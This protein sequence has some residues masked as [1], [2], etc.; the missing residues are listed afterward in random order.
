VRGD[1]RA[2]A[3][4]RAWIV[5]GGD[6]G[7]MI[8]GELFATA[9]REGSPR[10]L[11]AVGAPVIPPARAALRHA[12][13]DM[14]LVAIETL[15][16]LRVNA[17]AADIRPLLDD[18]DER[19]RYAACAALGELYDRPSAPAIA[20]LAEKDPFP[21]A[22]V[23]TLGL[24][25]VPGTEVA[26]VRLSRHDDFQIRAAV[27][28]AL[29]AFHDVDFTPAFA[30]LARDPVPYVRM[31]A[32]EAMALQKRSDTAPILEGQLSDPDWRVRAAAATAI[33]AIGSVTSGNGLIPLLHD[34][35]SEVRGE[36]AMSLAVLKRRDALPALLALRD[37]PTEWGLR[38]IVTAIGLFGGAETIPILREF[39]R[40]PHPRV[41]EAAQDAL[42][43]IEAG[44]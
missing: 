9:K 43:R 41:R 31:K 12:D 27:A 22:A 28:I 13:A 23:R 20:R 39:A 15:G 25:A 11:K 17:A 42:D 8:V 29:G 18:A 7:Q 36:A 32:A 1:E 4:V 26:L 6:R 37:E 33:G 30:V 40:H 3:Q 35:R 10:V 44:K 5:A 34:A 19:V 38:R 16:A 21:L 14:R 24:L 2:A